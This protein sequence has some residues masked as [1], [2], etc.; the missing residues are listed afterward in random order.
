MQDR[1]QQGGAGPTLRRAK[2]L[3]EPLDFLMTKRQCAAY[4]IIT[5]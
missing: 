2:S 5:G 4:V 3:A 1:Y